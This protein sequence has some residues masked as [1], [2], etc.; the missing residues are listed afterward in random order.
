MEFKYEVKFDP[1][2]HFLEGEGSRL[3]RLAA[4]NQISVSVHAAYDEK[5]NLGT[6]DQDLLRYSRRRLKESIQFAQRVGAKYLTIHGGEL[7]LDS[8]LVPEEC[9]D[10]YPFQAVRAKLG[11]DAFHRF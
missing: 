7:A 11:V 8:P 4:D 9:G 5:L 6:T 3:G 10:C 2:G 1:H